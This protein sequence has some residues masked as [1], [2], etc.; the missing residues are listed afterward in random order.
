[1]PG[2]LTSL[3]VRVT[4][5][6]RVQK[7]VVEATDAGPLVRAYVSA[8]PEDGKANAAVIEL[9]AEALGLPKRALTIVRGETSRSKLVRIDRS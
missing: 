1:M 5:K 2:D 7:L 6:A 4:P 3:T 8:A 9:L